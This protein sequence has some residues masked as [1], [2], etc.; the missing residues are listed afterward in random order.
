MDKATL[1][2]LTLQYENYQKSHSC[3][4]IYGPEWSRWAWRLDTQ[5]GNRLTH[6]PPD[7]VRHPPPT[8][9]TVGGLYHFTSIT[10]YRYDIL[11]I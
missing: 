8:Q 7:M 10:I 6:K 4:H 9:T 5:R 3:S 2:L 1:L 11:L